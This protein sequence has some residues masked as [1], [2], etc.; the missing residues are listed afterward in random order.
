MGKYFFTEHNAI[1]RDHGH[2]FALS[3]RAIN[4]NLD[5]APISE[6]MDNNYITI[7]GIKNIIM[8]TTYNLLPDDPTMYEDA[9]R[10]DVTLN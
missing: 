8:E 4:F 5:G 7:K 2:N 3:V 10:E 1:V 9:G 6:L